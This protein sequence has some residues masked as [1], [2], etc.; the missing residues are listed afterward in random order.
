MN[1]TIVLMT[2]LLL[3]MA[4][5]G[6]G[7]KAN[8]ETDVIAVDVRKNYPEKEIRLQDVFHV[9]Y[10]PL[11]TND[12]FIT[13]ANIKAISAHYIVT[14]NMGSDGDIFLFDRK[15]GKGIRKINHKGQ[16][17]GEYSQAVFVNIDEAKDEM[18]VNDY[19]A[20]KIYVYDLSGNFKRKLDLPG[21]GYYYQNT[22]NYDSGHLISEIWCE[23]KLGIAILSKQDGNLTRELLT[24]ASQELSPIFTEGELAVTPPYY[25]IF[26][27]KEGW[28]MV[29]PSSDTI[30]HHSPAD[31]WLPSV[32]RTPALRSMDT[33]V[34]L[35]PT[36]ITER[37][38]FMRSMK[39]E[40]DFKTFKGFPS[41][42]LAYDRQTDELFRCKLYNDD[43]TDK[44]GVSLLAPP[45]EYPVALARPL[46]S[47]DLVEAYQSGKLQGHLK[48]IA[49]TLNEE[50]NA[51]IMILSAKTE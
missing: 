23:N 26:Q 27:T 13:S 38:Y 18:F 3:A 29:N 31:E 44:Q 22:L 51:V 35:T 4:G 32:V 40:L 30:F 34:F 24:P 9:E 5:C 10:V 8:T 42:E 14:T 36:T 20:R 11:E 21:D 49:A 47:P 33:Q 25:M 15:T 17:E 50:S 1:K 48:E 7:D 43:F 16:G 2:T 37:Y 12:E 19:P 39:K 45:C 28:E 41:E 46:Q 6:T